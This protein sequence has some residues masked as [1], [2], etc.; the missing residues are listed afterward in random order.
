[1]Q[2]KLT[3]AGYRGIWGETLT[4]EIA[5]G[6]ARAFAQFALKRSGKRILIGRDARPSGS[7]LVDVVSRE[8][9]SAGLEV[10]IGGLLP[11]PTVLF[12]VRE[13][14]FD[15]AIIVTASHNPPEYNGLKFVTSRG[16]FTN[17]N[18]VEELKELLNHP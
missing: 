4:P 7:E 11:T 15:G 16:M 6:F 1:M 3:V 12:L 14:K 13:E 2:P 8:L 9:A 17:E 18:E 10:T 5:S